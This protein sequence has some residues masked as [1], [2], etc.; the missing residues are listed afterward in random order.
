MVF[1]LKKKNKT[2]CSREQCAVEPYSTVDVILKPVAHWLKLMGLISENHFF[3]YYQ[4]LKY[5]V[6]G[7]PHP[8]PQN[9]TPTLFMLQPQQS[10]RLI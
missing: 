4:T 3:S 10:L 6:M 1:F 2:N 8:Q 7:E 9:K 5:M